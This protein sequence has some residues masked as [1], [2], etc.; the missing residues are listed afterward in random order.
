VNGKSIIYVLVKAFKQKCHRSL[1]KNTSK[2]QLP[3]RGGDITVHATFHIPGLD[4]LYI[5]EVYEK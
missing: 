1:N 2:N 4:Q 3:E 5:T